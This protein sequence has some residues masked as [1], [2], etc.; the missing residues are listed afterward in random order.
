MKKLLTLLITIFSMWGK[1]SAQLKGDG[2]TDNSVV[3]DS[4]VKKG[5]QIYLPYGRVILKKGIESGKVFLKDFTNPSYKAIDAVPYQNAKFSP[6]IQIEGHPL[7]TTIVLDNTD[8][9]MAVL[10][11]NAQALQY[12]NRITRIKN[13]TLMGKGIGISSAYTQKLQLDNVVFKGFSTGLLLNN[14]YYVKGDNLHFENCNRAEYDIRSH[15]S[16]FTN[17]TVYDCK[18]GFEIRSNKVGI[19]GY[20]AMRCYTGL[21]VASAVNTFDRVVLETDKPTPQLIIGDSTGERADGNTFINMTISAPNMKAIRFEKTCG[22]LTII[23]GQI[24]STNFEIIGKPL[25]QQIGLI[26]SLPKEIIKI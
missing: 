9:S 22:F 6:A 11:L 7:G 25:V 12:D 8:T 17:T 15:N 13:V 4:L 16:Q 26:G 21:Q 10:A 14:A 23:G 19:Y 2:I 3:F 1:C 20:T 24:Q 18:K 5:G